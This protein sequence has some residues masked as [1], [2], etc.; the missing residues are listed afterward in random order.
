MTVQILIAAA[1][2][3]AFSL[4]GIVAVFVAREGARA[5]TERRA[6]RA[7]RR[8]AAIVDGLRSDAPEWFAPA[9]DRLRALP[10]PALREALLWTARE[11][12]GEAAAARLGPLFDACGITAAAAVALRDSTSWERRALAAERLGLIGSADGVAPLLEVLRDARDEDDDVRGAALRA[13]GRIRDPRALPQL[14]ETLGDP[15]ASLPQRVA[16]IIV[17]IGKPAVL[18]LCRELAN[19][20]SDP[21]RAWAAEI[22]GWLGGHDAAAPLIEALGDVNPEVRAK[23]AG[24]VARLAETR[25]VDRL[26]EM[27]LADPIPF[28]RTRAAQ[29]LGALGDPR[30]IDHLIHVLRDPEWW[31]RVR[32]V[33]ALEMIGRPAV[34]PLLGALEDDDAQVRRRAAIGLE[35]MGYV[36]EAVA[37]LERDGFRADLH[38]VLDLVGR[39]GV[40][41][42][43]FG[44]L[45]TAG[46]PADKLLVRLAGSFGDPGAIPVLEA[47]LAES[48]DASLRSR[49]IEALGKL[50]AKDSAGRIVPCLGDPSEWV[51]RAAV[52]ALARI[53]AE[54]HVPE[55]LALVHD[56]HVDTRTTVCRALAGVA[57]PALDPHLA[58]L[59]GDPAPAVRTEALRAM[60][61]RQ[62]ASAATTARELLGDVS[63][64]VR[65]EAALALAEIG[66]P[67]DVPA[68]CAASRGASARFEAAAA[69]ALRRCHAGGFAELL[70]LAGDAPNAPL[71]G[72]LLHVAGAL[73]GADALLYVDRHLLVPD[74]GLR[75]GAALALAAFEPAATEHALLTALID[76]DAGVRDAAVQVAGLT[77]SIVLTDRAG[78]L[79]LDPHPDVRFHFALAL[80]LAPSADVGLLRSLATDN[81][82]RVRA[83]A[84]LALA[85]ADPQALRDAAAR[86]V[87]DRALSD[88]ARAA[89]E[90]DSADPLV[91]AVVNEARRAGGLECRLFLGGSLL[92]LEKET[93][94]RAREAL[95]E[96]ERIHALE[97]CQL[98]ATGESYTAALAILRNDPSPEVRARALDLLVTIR[99]DGEVAKA[100]AGLLLDPHPRVRAK[101]ARALGTLEVP[102][103]VEALIYALDTPERD[104]REEVTT[105]LSYHLLREPARS[106]ALIAEMPEG[107]SRRL[108]IVWVLGKTRREG[109]M[110]ALHR[111]LADE[112]PD[113]RAAAIGA[114]AKFPPGIAA[115]PIKKCLVDPNPRVRAAAV[116]ALSRLRRPEWEARLATMLSDPDVFV[117]QRAAVAL[118]RMNA[119]GAEPRLRAWAD[120][121]EELRP[122]WLAG[123]LLRGLVDASTAASHPATARFLR[124]LCGEED[125]LRAVRGIGDPHKRLTGLAV[126]M[127]LAPEIAW[128]EAERLASDPDPSVRA[129]AQR[130]AAPVEA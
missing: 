22:L 60:R 91:A 17:R 124:E 20:A 46:P 118:L 38:R 77:R 90:G 112:D 56:A 18:P 44:R 88:A 123:G 100:V 13:L 49:V 29:A 24:A 28:V 98:V 7:V 127:V 101:A 106:E 79:L 57:D 47:L 50:E 54:N 36:D 21:R 104:L 4:V 119:A 2:L 89:F 59:L 31:V 129:A 58:G 6:A 11:G 34:G 66:G 5:W 85:L 83:A 84:V 114:L 69:T 1:L 10:S 26:L 121:P 97:I 109:A 43:L 82:A 130:L 81:D 115:R 42:V 12:A 19:T 30:V 65:V 122:V 39:A 27:L 113:V 41:E 67:A 93:A 53:G 120:E 96:S 76:P 63:D 80:A 37:T 94:Q 71:A 125:A 14:I 107:K 62:V 35:R 116:N 61:V 70:A 25:A 92:T 78:E 68:L 40:T 126:L 3:L 111:Y 103:A 45:R 128:V 72:V 52:A 15:D 102:E 8:H 117:R 33:E 32:A 110:K 9:C 64:D 108:G 51:R 73:G 74:A 16:E 95:A 48:S 86:Y 55:L 75:R 105:A 87:A 99:R 23:A